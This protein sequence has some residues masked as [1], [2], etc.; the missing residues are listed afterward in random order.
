MSGFYHIDAYGNVW[1][2]D[3][4]PLRARQFVSRGSTEETIPIE[5]GPTGV[6]EPG[7]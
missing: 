3:D 5:D 6:A 2:L 7:E 1:W 4:W